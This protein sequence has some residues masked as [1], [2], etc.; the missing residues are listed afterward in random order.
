MVLHT[1]TRAHAQGIIFILISDW[2]ECK[3]MSHCVRHVHVDVVAQNYYCNPYRVPDVECVWNAMAHAQKPDFVFRRKRRVHLNW[4]GRRFS[5]LLAAE[6]CASVLVMLDA[7]CS[8]VVW[9]YWLPTPFASF[10]FTSPPVHHHVPSGLKCTLPF[11]LWWA[12]IQQYITGK[13]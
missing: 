10:P 6:V 4:R 11:F 5:R 1:H 12:H 2:M 3:D 8:E 13:L 9:E 7:P